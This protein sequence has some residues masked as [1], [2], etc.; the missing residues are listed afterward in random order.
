MRSAAAPRLVFSD[1]SRLAALSHH[2]V[3]TNHLF[4]SNASRFIGLLD[5]RYP[6]RYTVQKAI[7]DN[8]SSMH[9]QSTLDFQHPD[10]SVQTTLH[11]DMSGILLTRSKKAKQILIHS[12]DLGMHDDNIE[13]NSAIFSMSRPFETANSMAHIETSG[14]PIID[15]HSP[16]DRNCGAVIVPYFGTFTKYKEGEEKDGNKVQSIYNAIVMHQSYLGDVHAQRVFVTSPQQTWGYA[17]RSSDGQPLNQKYNSTLGTKNLR[18]DTDAELGV[19]LKF[20]RR[21]HSDRGDTTGLSLTNNL[22]DID[23]DMD[24]YPISRSEIVP[25]LQE[26]DMASHEIIDEGPSKSEDDDLLG[27]RYMDYTSEQTIIEEA[28]SD[29]QSFFDDHVICTL[30]NICILFKKK[31]KLLIEDLNVLRNS[32]KNHPSLTE[33]FVDVDDDW[34]SRL[35]VLFIL[36]KNSEEEEQRHQ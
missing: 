8:A 21:N 17:K 25:A 31:Y 6:K 4:V 7:Y 10:H 1:V 34:F 14:V 2:T 28:L 12:F 11:H 22:F 24:E 9:F 15:Q 26:N 3:S 18:V 13:R 35:S 32:L 36:D 33:S 20:S 30:E 23:C 5:L 27:L 29:V 16:H 19:P